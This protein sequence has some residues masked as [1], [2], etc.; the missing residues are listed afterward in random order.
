MR[1]T[2][3]QREAWGPTGDPER[4]RSLAELTA[5]WQAMPADPDDAGELRLICRRLADGRRETPDE[6]LL[7]LEEGVPGDGW[8]RRP[9]RDPE[10]QLAVINHALASLLANG[11]PVTH[12]G[13]NLYVRLNLDAA[14]LPTGTRLRIGDAEVTVS[15]KPHNGCAKFHDRFG[16]DALRFVQASATRHH[17][18]RGIYWVVSRPGRIWAGAPI[19][20]TERPQP[21]A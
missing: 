17:N 21:T 18:L 11:Q 1:R 3:L 15:P 8:S 10:A 16:A 20:V 4:H 14:N 9:P 5:A 19:S 6:V 13:D 7:S 2:E 12:S